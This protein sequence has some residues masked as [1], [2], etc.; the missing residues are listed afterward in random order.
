VPKQHYLTLHGTSTHWDVIG[1]NSI[2]ESTPKGFRVYIRYSSDAPMNL[3][4]SSSYGFKLKYAIE[5][6]EC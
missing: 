2:Y 6:D 5:T 4:T 3:T 1:Y